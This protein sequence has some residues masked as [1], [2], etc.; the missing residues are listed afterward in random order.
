MTG[1][2]RFQITGLRIIN[3]RGAVAAGRCEA[4]SIATP[5]NGHDPVRV[6]LNDQ[7]LFARAN[8]VNANGIVR[9]AHGEPRTVRTEAQRQRRVG[10]GAE[11]FHQGAIRRIKQS[12]LAQFSR[13]T[14]GRGEQRAVPAVIEAVRPLRDLLDAAQKFSVGRIPNRD[15]VIAA[16]CQFTSVRVERQR[17]NRHRMAIDRGRIGMRRLRNERDEW[18]LGVGAVECRACFDPARDERNLH[19]GQWIVLLR[20]PVVLILGGDA[21]E[22]FA[23]FGLAR[24]NRRGFAFTGFHQQLKAV[25]AEMAFRFLRAVAG[26][27]FFRQNRRDAFAKA[28]CLRAFAFLS[29]DRKR[30][31]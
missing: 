11:D 7:L 12:R 16:D 25:E 26:D 29:K 9:A 19:G 17:R 2:T 14:A 20:H 22:Q 15:F 24:N 13:R 10:H 21:A 5:G 4:R 6:L 18:R 28:D 27:A 8:I 23:L 30:T 1:I 3:T 31:E